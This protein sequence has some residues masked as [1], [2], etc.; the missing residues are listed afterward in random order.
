MTEER[1]NLVA[2][3]RARLANYARQ[4]GRPFHE[5][6]QY[7]AIERFLYRLAESPYCEE[8]VLKGG[9]AFLAWGVP[10][11]RPTRDI[12]LHGFISNSTDT[13]EAIFADICRQPVVADGMS[14]DASTIETSVIQNRATYHGVRIQFQGNLGTA[15]VVMQV[16]VGFSDVLTS[17]TLTVDYATVLNMP[18]PQLRAYPYEALIAEKFH[19]MVFLGRINSRMK[20]FF[21]VWTLINSV[22]VHGP[23]VQRAIVSTFQNRETRI[24]DD[25][26]VALEETFAV[27]KQAEWNAF[28]R[29]TGD[30]TNNISDFRDVIT[31]LRSFF[32]PVIEALYHDSVLEDVWRPATGWE[33][34]DHLSQGGV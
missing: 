12:D 18:R 1:Q 17:P 32:L 11:R 30:G 21:D 8:F 25:C 15:R 23:A 31:E 5:V 34:L 19:A 27:G 22:T 10:L 14:F 33:K 6:M 7:Y 3:I 29:R 26:P 16:D 20:D 2:S 24:P 13:I 4:Q 28:L 9:L